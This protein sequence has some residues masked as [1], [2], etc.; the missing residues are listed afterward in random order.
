MLLDPSILALA[1]QPRLVQKQR[2]SPPPLSPGVEVPLASLELLV[3][4][5]QQGEVR[6]GRQSSLEDLARER[7][8]AFLHRPVGQPDDPFPLDCRAVSISAPR[9][10]K[11]IIGAFFA[12][13]SR[14]L[15]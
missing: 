2:T 11:R 10:S 8:L 5:P 12:L 1:K 4:F 14:V 7:A 13:A 15:C 6:P 9:A 3:L